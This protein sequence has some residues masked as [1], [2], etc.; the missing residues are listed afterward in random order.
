MSLGP[1]VS[2]RELLWIKDAWKVEVNV[3]HKQPLEAFHDSG[4]QGHRTLVIK[5]DEDSNENSSSKLN[6]SF[7]ICCLIC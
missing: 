1:V 7:L 5:Y 6:F 3:C 4:C 2:V